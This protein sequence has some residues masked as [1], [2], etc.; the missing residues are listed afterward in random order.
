MPHP[1]LTLDLVQSP[2]A[3]TPRELAVAELATLS[4]ADIALALGISHYTVKAHLSN[5]KLKTGLETR[6]AIA[7]WADRQTRR[8]A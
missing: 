8:A 4:N 6:A 5:L 7:V 3:V 2:R 1:A